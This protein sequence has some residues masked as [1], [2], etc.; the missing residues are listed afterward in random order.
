MDERIQVA[1]PESDDDLLVEI[2]PVEST[3]ATTILCPSCLLDD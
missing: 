2:D 3:G 1:D